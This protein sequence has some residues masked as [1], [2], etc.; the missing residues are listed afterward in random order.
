[1]FDT[2]AS[3]SSCPC[4]VGEFTGKSQPVPS[5][6]NDGKFSVTGK[7]KTMA[8]W[9]DVKL[10]CRKEPVQVNTANGSYHSHRLH[11]LDEQLS[12]RV[13]DSEEVEV[14]RLLLPPDIEKTFSRTTSLIDQPLPTP[15][16][17]DQHL[18]GTRYCVQIFHHK[19]FE[20]R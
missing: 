6:S 19:Y 1:M 2:G 17:I 12:M 15:S 5:C 13:G 16:L 7:W 18:L 8:F 11:F 14:K 4:Y 20:E 3:D 10:A 9:G